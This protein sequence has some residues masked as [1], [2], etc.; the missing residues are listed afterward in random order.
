MRITISIN[1]QQN[2]ETCDIQVASEQKISDTLRVLRE[3]MSMFRNI[4]K[5]EYVRRK[6]S[7]RKIDIDNTYEQAHVYSGVM[8]VIPISVGND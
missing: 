7:G 4:G 5:V 6:D 2:N 8:L 3:N 1:L